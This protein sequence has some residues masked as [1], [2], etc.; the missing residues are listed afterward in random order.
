MAV[1]V[2]APATS[3]Y[4]WVVSEV[5]SAWSL[6]LGVLSS[7]PK[8]L[9]AVTLASSSDAVFSFFGSLTLAQSQLCLH[10]V[11]LA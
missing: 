3:F 6:Y 1:T 9:P 10:S 4:I 5:L 2:I 7:S 8:P 11:P